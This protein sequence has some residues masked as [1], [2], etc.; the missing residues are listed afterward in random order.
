MRCAKPS[1]PPR[2]LCGCGR[3][4]VTTPVHRGGDCGVFTRGADSLGT[5]P[6]VVVD[7]DVVNRPAALNAARGLVRSVESGRFG[8]HPVHRHYRGAPRVATPH[9]PDRVDLWHRGARLDWRGVRAGMCRVRP[10]GTWL[11][12][13]GRVGGLAL[14]L[15]IRAEWP[16]D[17]LLATAVS[18]WSASLRPMEAR[19]LVRR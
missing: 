8:L 17:R 12:S 15:V 1:N 3:P 9:E 13:V 7:D 6:R 18:E 4:R 2:C 16:G 19:R 14:R 11:T 10:G 5:D